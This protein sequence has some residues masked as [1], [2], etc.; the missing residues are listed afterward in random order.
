MSR[1]HVEAI[2]ENGVFRP[3]TGASEFHEGE[4]VSLVVEKASDAP[5]HSALAEAWQVY[6]GLSEREVEH[7][8]SIALDRS[9]WRQNGSDR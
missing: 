2:F 4:R 8:E 1:Q 6:E 7:L 9:H 3:I 5:A